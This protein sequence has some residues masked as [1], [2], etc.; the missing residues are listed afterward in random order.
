MSEVESAAERK[1]ALD[2]ALRYILVCTLRQLECLL[3]AIEFEHRGIKYR[4]DS[5]HEAAELVFNLD[6]HEA[7]HGSYRLREDKPTRVWTA[8]L[9]MDLLK[10]IG[11][12]QQKFIAILNG[13]ASV[14]SGRLAEELKLGSE[15]A[16]AG[17][18][19]GLSKQL[20]KMSIHPSSLYRV[21]VEWKGKEKV[22]SFALSSDF[23]D[24]LTELGWP[25]AW[26]AGK[27]NDAASTKKRVIL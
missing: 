7:L 3:V 11:E 19:S 10:G 17:V 24:A 12:M 15:V 22:R 25:E 8:D 1:F 13:G 5:A 4:V 16:L 23:R 18:V 6:Q 2:N 9:A 20:R 26:Q 14:K 27:E 21:D